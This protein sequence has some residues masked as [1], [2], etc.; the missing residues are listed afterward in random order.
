MLEGYAH[1]ARR[2][3]DFPD[4]PEAMDWDSRMI[5]LSVEGENEGWRVR[6]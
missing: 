5:T 6:K 2:P 3:P 4:A 1:R